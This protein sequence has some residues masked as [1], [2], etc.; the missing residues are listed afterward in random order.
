MDPLHHMLASLRQPWEVGWPA[1][2]SSTSSSNPS[3]LQTMVQHQGA[4]VQQIASQSAAASATDR[5]ED[6]RVAQLAA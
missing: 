6:V 1:L 2:L 4:V 5:A 3:A